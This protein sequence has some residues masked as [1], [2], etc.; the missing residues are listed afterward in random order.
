MKL[1]TKEI[2]MLTTKQVSEILGCCAITAKR[3]LENAG[4]K[5]KMQTSI[6]GNRRKHFFDITEQQLH[7]LILKQRKNAGKRVLQQAVSLRTLESMFNR[8]LRM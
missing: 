6:N 7:E 3:K 4:I 2:K 8:Q 5:A 1:L